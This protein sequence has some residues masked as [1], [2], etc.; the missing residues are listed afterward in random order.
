MNRTNRFLIGG[1]LL[2]A[3]IGWLIFT[4]VSETSVYYFTIDEFLARKESL[5]NEGVRVAGRVGGGT[6]KWDPRTTNL[7]FALGDFKAPDAGGVTVRYTGILPDMFAEGRDVIVE[8]KYGADGIFRAHSVL[9]SCP[10]KYE[11][12]AGP[13]GAQPQ[14]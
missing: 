13:D 8:G 10:S 12:E 2:A 9:T 11:A 5:A 4:A 14:S 3:A 1:V 7:E 6:V